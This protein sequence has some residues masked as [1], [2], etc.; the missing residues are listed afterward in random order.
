MNN[1]P[2]DGRQEACRWFFSLALCLLLVPGKS[3]GDHTPPTCTYSTDS[4]PP[5]P[6]A[7]MV[8]TGISG[9]ADYYNLGDPF[10]AALNFANTDGKVVVTTTHSDCSVSVDT[11]NCSISLVTNYYWTVSCGSIIRHGTNSLGTGSILL[12]NTGSGTVTFSHLN[13]TNACDGSTG[14]FPDATADFTVVDVGLKSVL[15]TTDHG[16]LTDYNTNYVGSGGTPYNP[17]GWQKTPLINNPIT[18]SQGTYVGVNVVINVTPSNV[19]FDLEGISD[20]SALTFHI[21]GQTST[22]SDQTIA[23]TSDA[24]LPAKIDKLD[25][26][27][28]WHVNLGSKQID[29]G[30]SGSHTV[31]VTWATPCGD[32]PTIKRVEWACNI[33]N[34]ANSITVAA[35]KFRDAIASNPGPAN[36]PNDNDST[37]NSWQFLDSNHHGDCIT[38][39]KLACE[40]LKIIGI[41]AQ[42]RWAWPTADGT[43]GFPAISGNTCQNRVTTTLPYQGQTFDAALV[44][45]GNNF[46]GFFTI[47]DPNIK[48]YTVY[49]TGGPFTNQTYYYLEVLQSVANGDQFWVWN[50]PGSPSFCIKNGVAVFNWNNVPGA[51]HIPVPSIP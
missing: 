38:L 41:S 34:S 3:F 16:V 30:S 40:G 28:Q 32:T 35:E 42:H 47:S 26:S 6:N 25:K 10:S 21:T 1:A 43:S 33:A 50:Y 2:Q 18:H 39:A 31:Y 7:T 49:P 48:A 29:A 23:L 17:H 15:F 44:Y 37:L 11:N 22:G 19:P 13:W 46:E 24:A 20:N 45:S 8:E 9:V 5:D 14:S 27:I 4:A 51:S 12:T 36:D